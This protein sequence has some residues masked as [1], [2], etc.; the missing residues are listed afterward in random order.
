MKQIH[1][2]I[3]GLTGIV[4][5]CAAVHVS[6]ADNGRYYGAPMSAVPYDQEVRL[7]SD[8]KSVTVR[9]LD[10]VRFMTA[11]GRDFYWRFDTERPD[12]FPLTNI[13]PSDIAVPSSTTVYVLPEIPIAP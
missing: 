7:G 12:V 10:I 13:A 2:R 9:R 3:L 8:T 5:A 4:L 6:A 1:S 11:D